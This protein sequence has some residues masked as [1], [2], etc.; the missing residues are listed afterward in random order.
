[1]IP[2]LALAAK[3]HHDSKVEEERER[4]LR[5]YRLALK[6]RFDRLIGKLT[7][8]P[9]FPIFLELSNVQPF[10][11][12]RDCYG[13]RWADSKDLGKEWTR[14]RR[15]IMKEVDN[16]RRWMKLTLLRIASIELS[17]IGR[18]LSR[19]IR[20]ELAISRDS[21][22]PSRFAGISNS[23]NSTGLDVNDPA[24]I[25]NSDLARLLNLY[26]MQ[27]FAF[28]DQDPGDYREALWSKF[29]E[30]NEETYQGPL[31]PRF[32]AYWHQALLQVLAVVDLE[33]G[34]AKTTAKVLEELRPHFFCGICL[35]RQT[36]KKSKGDVTEGMLASEVVSTVVSRF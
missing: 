9:S 29:D 18:P 27:A 35:G 4:K 19:D 8:F 10:W 12:W 15:R 20:S 3:A 11:N 17:R 26:S 36:K 7:L 2:A 34:P 23:K 24:T 25:S 1:L 30:I 5:G 21:R 32:D 22:R 14:T 13:W 16:A 6:P 33:D 31:F 28:S